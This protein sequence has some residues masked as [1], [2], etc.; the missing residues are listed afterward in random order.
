MYFQKPVKELLR[1][2]I[3]CDV[4]P[5]DTIVDGADVQDG[6]LVLNEESYDCFIIPYSEA[7]PGQVLSRL[8]DFAKKGLPI[9]FINQLPR[10]I[11]DEEYN[12]D[13]IDRLAANK[14]IEVVPL[15]QLARRLKESGFFDIRVKDRQPYL[16][17][18]HVKHSNM[19]VFMF[20]NEHPNQEIDSEVYLPVTEKV[21]FYDAYD[22][23]LLESGSVREGNGSLLGL[24]LLPSQSILVISGAALDDLDAVK[25]M[26]DME[27]CMSIE[28]PWSVAMATSEQYPAFRPWRTLEKL[29]DLSR[30]EFL[31]AFSG[32]FRYETGFTWSRAPGKRVVIDLGEVFETAEV[33]LNGQSAGVRISPPYRF[34]ISREPKGTQ[35][36]FGY[37]IHRC[38]AAPMAR[39]ELQ[40]AFPALLRRFP[41]LRLAVPVEEVPIRT[42]NA[43]HGVF[44]LPVTW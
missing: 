1:N 38:V 34:D 11:S 41:T 9:F 4:L 24:K 2:Q 23:R 16:R 30:P 42:S 22:N 5:C 36:A 6:K 20:F 43:T 18:Y 32:T 37:G 3:D 27:L 28:G 31:P 39:L 19:D 8:F 21:Y 12:R 35:L 33:F 25:R 14:R 7:L 17:Y 10:R 15:D 40:I 44:A 29:S 13:I 26:P